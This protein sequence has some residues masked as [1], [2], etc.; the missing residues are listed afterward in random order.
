ML[1]HVEIKSYRGFKSYRMEGLAQV[2]LFV[3]RNNSGKTAL[4]EG[5]QLLASGGD[6][7]VLAESATRRGEVVV[8]RPDPSPLVDIAHFFNGHVLSLDSSMSFRGDNG[9]A[10]VALKV[11]ST[12]SDGGDTGE[13][14]QSSDGIFLKI[15]GPYKSERDE[16]R[17]PI[18]REGGVDFDLP[19]RFRRGVGPARRSFGPPVRFI[20]PDSLN[21]IDLAMMWDEITLTGQEVDVASAMRVLDSN[22]DT[23][24]FLTG[25]MS[26]GYF[27]ARGGIVVGMKGHEARVP[28]GSMGDGMR[29][30]M[31]IATAL[32]FTKHGCLFIDEIDTGLHYSVMMDMWRL[33]VNKAIA[34]NSQ[35]F[36][37]THSWD[38]IEGMSALVQSDPA[39]SDKIAIHKI[40]RSIP[41]SVAFSGDSI[42][43]MVKADIDPR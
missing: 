6:P 3:G 32:A 41:H 37:T 7:G 24:H 13:V 34:S 38:C 16:P 36:A 8:A 2:N 4:L 18:S 22:L 33:I 31:A 17:F 15:S 35:V 9:Y 10:P 12:K 5:I 21:S 39:F 23:L 27:P 1:K 14:R 28:L 25:M 42:V 19:A 43:R 29:R 26:G 11:F 30:M 20:G 40:D